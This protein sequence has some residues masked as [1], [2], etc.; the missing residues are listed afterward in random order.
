MTD[1]PGSSRRNKTPLI[2]AGVVLA[3]LAAGGLY[4][5]F[6][7]DLLSRSVSYLDETMPAGLF[8]TLF[9]VLPIFGAPFSPFLILAGIKFG[10][11][12]GLGLLMAAMPVHMLVTFGIAHLLHRQLRR[13]MER[14]GYT[15]PE[16]PSE[17]AALYSFIWL[18]LP[19][20]PYAVKNFALPLAGV[21]FRHCLWMNWAVQGVYAV[22]FVV[23]GRSAAEMNAAIFLAAIALLGGAYGLV[24]WLK[25]RYHAEVERMA[26]GE[27]SG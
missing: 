18:A 10:V 25:R 24:R 1:A 21:P 3:L 17:R 11:W 6:K 13:F 22:G 8:L 4:L 27:E 7:H 19:G 2:L 9:A 23:L 20:M 14:F 26:E 16:I 12:G 15:V 5:I